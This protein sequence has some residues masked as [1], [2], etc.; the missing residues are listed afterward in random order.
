MYIHRVLCS[1]EKE[2]FFY[3]DCHTIWHSNISIVIIC[4]STVC[5]SPYTM[6]VKSQLYSVIDLL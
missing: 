6:V 1:K 5:I 2:V 3:S 4:I